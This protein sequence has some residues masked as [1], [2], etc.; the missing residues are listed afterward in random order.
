[1]GFS[2]KHFLST[3]YDIKCT[4]PAEYGGD[5]VQTI[6]L[7]LRLASKQEDLD[8]QAE[9]NASALNTQSNGEG[10][11]GGDAENSLQILKNHI[12]RLIA[13]EPI[14]LDDFPQTTEPLETRARNYFNDNPTALQTFI[15]AM[16]LEVWNRYRAATGVSAFFR[17]F[18]RDSAR[19]GGR[20][21]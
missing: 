13:N 19:D 21:D 6:I 4:V 18:Q 1:M 9:I 5:G 11:N 16:L 8:F 12:C 17:L 14:G 20:G 2:K 15:D 3:I 7:P 10:V